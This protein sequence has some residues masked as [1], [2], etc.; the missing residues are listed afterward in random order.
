MTKIP[1]IK[2]C[3][4]GRGE[5]YRR[6][7]LFELIFEVT[8]PTLNNSRG[9]WITTWK[10]PLSTVASSPKVYLCQTVNGPES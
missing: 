6:R 5:G 9:L 7:G 3:E 4:L 8:V 1:S 10:S 2:T